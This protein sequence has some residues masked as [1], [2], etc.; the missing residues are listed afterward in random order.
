MSGLNQSL[1]IIDF[2]RILLQRLLTSM[3]LIKASISVSGSMEIYLERIEIEDFNFQAPNKNRERIV[4]NDF[5]IF[6]IK[7]KQIS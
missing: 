5:Q 4:E 7:R 6:K 2:H 1:N 3:D